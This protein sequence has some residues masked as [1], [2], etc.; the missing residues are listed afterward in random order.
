MI[1]ALYAKNPTIP[2]E[3]EDRADAIV[4]GMGVADAAMLEVITGQHESVGRLPVV[5]PKDMDTVEANAEDTPF[6]VEAYVDSE[7]N[8]WD[9][10]F[11]LSCDGTPLSA[12]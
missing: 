3:F 10:G 12:P 2:V 1:V 8:A 4:I 11:G 9:H 7:G 5:F 6:D